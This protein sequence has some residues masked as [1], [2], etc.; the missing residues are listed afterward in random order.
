[1]TQY[2]AG[3]V[4]GRRPAPEVPRVDPL[5]HRESVVRRLLDLDISP[6]VLRTILP[7]LSGVIDRVTGPR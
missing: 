4:N 2:E 5:A 3:R 1:M 7:E 6:G